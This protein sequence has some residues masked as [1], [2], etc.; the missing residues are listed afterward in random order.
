[1]AF[2]WASSQKASCPGSYPLTGPA[3]GTRGHAVSVCCEFSPTMGPGEVSLG[4][5]AASAPVPGVPIPTS[6]FLPLALSPG[7]FNPHAVSWSSV[8]TSQGFIKPRNQRQ[9]C[10]HPFW[11]EDL[12]LSEGCERAQD[13]KVSPTTGCQPGVLVPW[14]QP[15]RTVES[16]GLGIPGHRHA[17]GSWA[18]YLSCFLWSA[19]PACWQERRGAVWPGA[20]LPGCPVCL[21]APHL[22]FIRTKSFLDV[23]W[24]NVPSAIEA[25][26]PAPWRRAKLRG[27]IVCPGAW[28][29]RTH[30]GS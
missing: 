6:C 30:V 7:M 2:S 24:F 29:V 23:T 26:P 22:A 25:R 5:S 8:V 9:N 13:S 15:C 21:V 18:P 28:L 11:E 10:V 27:V 16:L 20:S 17:V 3:E 12:S 14:P 1:M 4:T 19:A